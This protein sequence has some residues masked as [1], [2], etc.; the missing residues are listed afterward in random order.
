MVKIL[1]LPKDPLY[2]KRVSCNHCASQL[3]YTKNEVKSVHGTDYS[4]G[5]D[6]YEWIDCPVC[7]NKVILK[8]W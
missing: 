2:V 1:D 7:F 8:S 4:G 3:E 5:P 6:G